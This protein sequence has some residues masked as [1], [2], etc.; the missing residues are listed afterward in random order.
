MDIH[1]RGLGERIVEEKELTDLIKEELN[2]AIE[3]FKKIFLA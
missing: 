3:E 2:K 1:N